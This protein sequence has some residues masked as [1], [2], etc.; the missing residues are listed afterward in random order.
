MDS[1]LYAAC[2]GLVARTQALD[3][4]ANNLANTST[5]AFRAELPTFRAELAAQNL[6]TADARTLAVNQHSMVG[7]T[8]LDMS[9]GNLETT[10]N[11]LDLGIEGNGFFEVR[12]EGTT[13]F[14]RNGSFRLTPDRTLVTDAGD[15]VLG[16]TGPIQLPDGEITISSDGTVS[17]GGAIA[18]KIKVVEF[19]PGTPIAHSGGSYYTGPVAA[20]SP[21]TNSAIRQGMLEA[22]NVNSVTAAVGLIALQRHAEMLHRT[23]S[24]FHN[25]FNRLA[26][27]ELPR[28]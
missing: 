24:T 23:L 14:T 28:V 10:G 17:V 18:A 16:E 9:Q 20:A 7:G 1:G 15:P 19:A 21:S 22:S 27:E 6:R 3:L 8:R 5:T 4:A 11:P 2:A 26:A 13:V 12:A 25:E